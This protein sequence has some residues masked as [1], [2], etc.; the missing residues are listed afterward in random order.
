MKKPLLII[1]LIIFVLFLNSCKDEKKNIEVKL[2]DEEHIEKQDTLVK[3]EQDSSDSTENSIFSDTLQYIGEGEYG[4][5]FVSLFL[6]KNFEV[7]RIVMSDKQPLKIEHL[8]KMLT[9][10]WKNRLLTAAGDSEV[11]FEMAFMDRFEFMD[12]KPFKHITNTT[13]Y[14]DLSQ[15]NT[16]ILEFLHNNKDK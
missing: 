10:K 11:K 7:I 14:N 16:V 9:A 3:I 1:I 15:F 2:E 12:S 13:D 6:T 4:D 5:N 8:N